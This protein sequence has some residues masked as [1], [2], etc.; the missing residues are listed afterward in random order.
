MTSHPDPAVAET[1]ARWEADE[2]RVRATLGPPGVARPEQIADLSGLEWFAA[3]SRGDLPS[4]PIGATMDFVP[5]DYG[6][7]RFVFQGRP[8]LRFA[9]PMGTI[10]G[11]WIATLLDS[12]VACAVHT[13]LPAG[14]AYTTAELKISYVRALTASVPMVRAEGRVIHAGR[15]AGFAEGRLVGPDGKLYAHATTTCIVLS[16][17]RAE[18]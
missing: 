6:Q 11:G 18:G 7:G 17:R 9:N 12:C 15:Q 2:A 16:T 4:V 14:R 10:H 13:T 5:V 1:L 8:S 3:I